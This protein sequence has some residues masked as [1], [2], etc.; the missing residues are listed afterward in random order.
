MR[1]LLCVDGHRGLVGVGLLCAAER[2]AS[3][4]HHHVCARFVLL[5]RTKRGRRT[6]A[7]ARKHAKR[8]DQD[9]LYPGPVLI[10]R[11]QRTLPKRATT[12]RP[13]PPA[14]ARLH[15]RRKVCTG[16]MACCPGRLPVFCPGSAPLEWQACCALT[17]S[18]KHDPFSILAPGPPKEFARATAFLFL[19][20]F[21]G[22]WDCRS[23]LR[24]SLRV[25]C[26][27][28]RLGRCVLL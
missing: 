22:R 1:R 5:M 17:L 25:S 18:D 21:G 16:M 14:P 11:S 23:R 2:A 26:G 28:G 19:P 27:R 24:V 13:L 7:S 3:H 6:R 20:F 8:R 15:A 10:P 9:D 12:P 4:R